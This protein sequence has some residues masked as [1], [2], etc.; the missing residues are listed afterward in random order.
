MTDII[1]N[2]ENKSFFGF[3][4]MTLEVLSRYYISPCFTVIYVKEGSGKWHIG[5]EIC[6]VKAGD[7]LFLSSYE[8]RRLVE[9][10]LQIMN[11][12]FPAE[13]FNA[14]ER[15]LCDRLFFLAKNRHVLQ[16]EALQKSF[17]EAISEM[18]G[19]G[20]FPLIFAYTLTLLCTAI[21]EYKKDA[22]AISPLSVRHARLIN[23]VKET[24]SNHYAEPLSVPALA[25]SVGMSAGHFSRVF[26]ACVG[27]SPAEYLL[28]YRI[29]VFLSKLSS[30][31]NILSLA[32]DTGFT[33]T[34]G[35]YKAFRSVVGCSPKQYLKIQK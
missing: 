33:S 3:H 29:T 14:V 5:T 11:L 32:F 12:W 22:V 24:V 10:K 4:E 27:K 28:H 31:Q 1:V 25:A 20:S 8:H 34:A 30:A 18:T 6:E 7:V 15:D 17:R 35:F 26:K 13:T 2:G 21:R 9:G 19:G 16:S 23:E